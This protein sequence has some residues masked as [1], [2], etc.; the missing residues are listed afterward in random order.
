M[1]W[2]CGY[3]NMLNSDM[4]EYCCNCHRMKDYLARGEDDALA[5]ASFLPEPT[6]LRASCFGGVKNSD[7]HQCNV[8]PLLNFL[9]N[10]LS[11]DH[12]TSAPSEDP[13][14]GED[15]IPLWF[16][17]DCG[18]GPFRVKNNLACARCD[19]TRCDNCKVQNVP[20]G[21]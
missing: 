11:I 12:T 10:H 19:H 4:D 3:C 17:C 21:N 8:A 5:L 15:P 1:R 18:D 2:Y 14:E 16:C 20:G 13:V 9:L 7:S 6:A